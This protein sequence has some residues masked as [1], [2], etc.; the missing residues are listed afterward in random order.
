MGREKAKEFPQ[1]DIID[2]TCFFKIKNKRSLFAN[3]ICQIKFYV[4]SQVNY[5][6]AQM[7]QKIL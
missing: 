1:E 5:V 6:E 4:S 2:E 3:W 7:K